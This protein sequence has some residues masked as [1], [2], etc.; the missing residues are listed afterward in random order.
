MQETIKKSVRKRIDDGE[1]ESK[2]PHEGSAEINYSYI[3]DVAKLENQFKIDAL[4]E[5]GLTNHQRADKAFYYAWCD[6]HGSGLNEV[7]ICLKKY[8]D[9]LI[10]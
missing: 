10:G 4:E 7:L 5:V 8:A 9:L 2:L 1:Y 6:G 3:Y